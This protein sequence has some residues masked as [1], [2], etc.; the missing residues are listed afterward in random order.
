MHCTCSQQSAFKVTIGLPKRLD[1]SPLVGFLSNTSPSLPPVML[2]LL[3]TVL[4]ERPPYL[5]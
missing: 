1:L 4:R 3:G 5:Q 2:Q